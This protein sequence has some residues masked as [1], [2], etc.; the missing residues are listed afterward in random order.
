L[1][2]GRNFNKRSGCFW[3]KPKHVDWFLFKEIRDL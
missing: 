3:R 2:R 1:Q